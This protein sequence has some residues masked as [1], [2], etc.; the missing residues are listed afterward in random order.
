MV[1]QH[2]SGNVAA[3]SVCCKEEEEEELREE[4]LFLFIGGN[5]ISYADPIGDDFRVMF[6]ISEITGLRFL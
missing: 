5:G 1:S 6:V 2:S 4:V 3:T